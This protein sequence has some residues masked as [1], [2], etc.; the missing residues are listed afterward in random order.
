MNNQTLLVNKH[1]LYNVPKDNDTCVVMCFFNPANYNSTIYNANIVINKLLNSKIPLF[2]TELLYENQTSSLDYK[3]QTVYSESVIFSK[4]NLWNITEKIIPDNYSKIIFLD[5]DINFNNLNWFNE[6]SIL[7]DRYKIIQPMEDCVQYIYDE[8]VAKIDLSYLKKG[9]A[10]G[11][12]NTKLLSSLLNSRFHPGYS[13][14]IKR[15]VFKKING[16]FE[17]SIIGGGDGLFWAS[18]G[19]MIDNESAKYRADLAYLYLK[20]K[21]N[22]HKILSIKDVGYLSN[23]TALH[24]YH[25]SHKNRNYKNRHSY[26]NPLNIDN[27]YHNQYGVLEVRDEPEIIQ[28]FLSR[29]EDGLKSIIS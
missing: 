19:C 28:Y 5:A 17:H 13:V 27:F 21:I 8:Q 24:L 3:T 9:I 2:L 23:T 4:E 1:D 16:F 25:G 18:F 7:L 10:Y 22:N 11:I 20:Y 14:G 15:D 6:S 12:N 26:I 29:E